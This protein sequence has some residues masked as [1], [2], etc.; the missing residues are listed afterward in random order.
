MAQLRAASAANLRERAR[1]ARRRVVFLLPLVIGVLLLN[2][3]RKQL[4][5]L[6]QPV[7]LASAVALVGLGAWFARDFGRALLPALTRRVDP[8]TAGT[9]GFVVRLVTLAVAVLIAL[10]IAGLTPGT[11]AVGG[12]VT[13]V[14]L[15][16]AAQSTIGN[17]F[18]GVLLLSVQP[19]RVGERVRL[20]AGALAG[21]MEGTVSQLGLLY[22]T[23]TQGD[24]VILVPNNTVITAAIVPLRQPGKV[25]VR[26]HLRPGV[27]PSELQ[28]MIEQMVTIPTRDH[29]HIELEEIDDDEVV[30]RVTATPA[31]NADGP[32]L[33][34][35]VLAALNAATTETVTSDGAH[36][37]SG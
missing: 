5:H 19:F 13:A 15:G 16:L 2:H 17:L 33:A 6:D 29:P 28:R 34:D 26:A 18:A 36:N 3:Y 22:V 32:R 4:F 27:K 10:N 30:M 37:G 25:D 31:S 21:T 35:E 24:D 11:L 20:Q 23:L 7:R 14:V 1:S 9:V 8:A 12:A